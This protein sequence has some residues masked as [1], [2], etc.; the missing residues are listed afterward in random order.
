MLLH[1][2]LEECWDKI[3]SLIRLF[4]KAR[5]ITSVGVKKL[6]NLEK[7]EMSLIANFYRGDP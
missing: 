4:V 5:D 2:D 6:I 3:K 7:A 1:S